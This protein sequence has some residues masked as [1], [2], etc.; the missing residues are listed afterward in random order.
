M[1][2]NKNHIDNLKKDE[3][4]VLELRAF[5]G[6]QRAGTL[7]DANLVRVACAFVRHCP[8]PETAHCP[9][10][11]CSP[12]TLSPRPPPPGGS[13]ERRTSAPLGGAEPLRQR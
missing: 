9:L 11:P 2:D 10:K 3:L 5:K 7:A 13:S 12:K 1:R 4:R 6:F 8:R